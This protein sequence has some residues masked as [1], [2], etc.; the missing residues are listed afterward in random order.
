MLPQYRERLLSLKRVL[1]EHKF[2]K[3]YIS[4]IWGLLH[5]TNPNKRISRIH[6]PAACETLLSYARS[7]LIKLK[8]H[9]EALAWKC[10][11]ANTDSVFLIPPEN[12]SPLC[13]KK[14]VESSFEHL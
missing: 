10:V 5:I 8:L 2:Y 6:N 1:E 13:V 14:Y 12:A 11:L 9:F 7:V 4:V 3:Q